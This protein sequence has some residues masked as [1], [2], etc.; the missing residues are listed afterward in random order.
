MCSVHIFLVVLVSE[1]FP[2]LFL[3][4]L[5]PAVSFVSK[6]SVSFCKSWPQCWT[7][8]MMGMS[9]WMFFFFS[10]FSK[11]CNKSLNYYL[12]HSLTILYVVDIDLITDEQSFSSATLTERGFSHLGLCDI[13]IK[14][15][16]H[17]FTPPQ[18]PVTKAPIIYVT[19]RYITLHCL[20]LSGLPTTKHFA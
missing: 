20:T 7:K 18:Y 16:V 15:S 17:N 4:P 11:Y 14:S 12:G 19:L 1:P 10:S 5:E 8:M 6:A 2:W 9:V 13:T 3:L